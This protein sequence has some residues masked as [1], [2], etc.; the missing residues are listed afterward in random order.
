MFLWLDGI[1]GKTLDEEVPGTQS[2]NIP[3]FTRFKQAHPKQAVLLHLNGNSRDPRCPRDAKGRTCSDVLAE[4]IAR[5]FLPGGALAAFDGLEGEASIA[6]RDKLALTPQRI[7]TWANGER[8]ESG[9]YWMS[10]AA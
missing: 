7:M 8:F 5:R 10:V 9:F 2:P 1:M 6:G 3:F 4:D